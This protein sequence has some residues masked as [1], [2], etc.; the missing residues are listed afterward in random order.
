MAAAV[1]KGGRALRRIAHQT[2]RKATD[3]MDAFKFNT[4]ISAMMAFNNY[5]VKAKETAIYGTEAW[6]EAVRSLLLL[7]APAVSGQ[8]ARTLILGGSRANW[9]AGGGGIDPVDR[10]GC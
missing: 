5:L 6:D 7:L 2:I 1:A 4:M 9:E 3:D 10:D 8:P